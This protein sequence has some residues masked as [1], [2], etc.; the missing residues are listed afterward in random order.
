MAS[1]ERAHPE[2]PGFQPGSPYRMKFEERY[3]WCNQYI[4]GK[5]IID[6]P[7]GCGWGT[8]LLEGYA[9]CHGADMDVD[10]IKYATKHYAK[11]NCDF[12]I[13]DMGAMGAYFV[14]PNNYDVVICLEGFEHVDVETGYAFLNVVKSLLKPG[15]LLL[16]TVPV[17]NPEGKHSGNPY[18][19]NEMYEQDFFHMITEHFRIQE[20]VRLDMPDNPIY[21]C[22]LVNR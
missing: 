14:T 6:I 12:V 7:C 18:H 1:A 11:L 8:S 3:K 9:H 2:H 21:R 10:S 13:V 16:M 17:R 5:R 20:A 4:K 15:G 22:V 19:L